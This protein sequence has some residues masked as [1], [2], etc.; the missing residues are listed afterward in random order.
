MSLTSSMPTSGIGAF[1][2]ALTHGHN[3]VAFYFSVEWL[4]ILVARTVTTVQGL[5]AEDGFH[6]IDGSLPYRSEDVKS[7]LCSCSHSWTTR[8]TCFLYLP[9][10]FEA[11]PQSRN[12][13]WRHINPPRHSMPQL[14]LCQNR[15][16]DISEAYCFICDNY[17]N[18]VEH[19]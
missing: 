13:R 9:C 15:S 17:L 5:V 6:F 18:E 2:A 14:F 12:H 4:T 10:L 7:V 3:Q 11:R 8:V 19:L 16:N 1:T